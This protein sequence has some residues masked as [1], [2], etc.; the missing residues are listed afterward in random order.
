MAQRNLQSALARAQGQPERANAALVLLPGQQALLTICANEEL[1]YTRRFDVPDGF[2]TGSWDES[3]APQAA[4]A[5]A[6][7]PVE[8]YVPDYAGST[9][10][11]YEPYTPAASPIR[12]DAASLSADKAQRM[13]VEVQRSLDVW[14]RT[15]SSLPLNQFRVYAGA[16]SVEL[17]LWLSSQ[18]GQTVVPL[19][20]G[21]L[22]AGLDVATLAEHAL[23]LPLLGVLL[24]HEGSTS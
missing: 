8:E 16:R 21:G 4:E 11:S 24:R 23:C 10:L 15:W 19:D 3:V 20:V 7:T 22:F 9:D 17:A 12:V 13:V 5:D 1:F 18:T 14:D 6:F 2:L